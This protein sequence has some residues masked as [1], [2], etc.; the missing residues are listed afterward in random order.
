MGF[1]IFVDTDVIIDFLID[2]HPHAISSSQIFE[3]QE[4][5]IVELFTSSLSINNVH[6]IINRVTGDKKARK[7]ILDLFQFIAVLD[8]TK[9]D[10]TNGLKSDFKDFEDAVQNSVALNEKNIKSIVTRNTK[11][12]KK[13][14]ISVFSPDT[15]IKMIKHEQ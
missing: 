12:F 15:F 1:K 6:Y 9:V 4:K 8:V 2:R 5:K 10:I 13:S 7:I 11:D 14:Q 3:L